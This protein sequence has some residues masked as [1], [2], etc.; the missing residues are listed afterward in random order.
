[1]GMDSAPAHGWV[2]SDEKLRELCPGEYQAL[3]DALDKTEDGETLGSLA[4]SLNNEVE[5]EDEELFHAYADLVEAFE[6]ATTIVEDHEREWNVQI[7]HG[8]LTLNLCY[9]DEDT[10]GSYDEISGDHYWNVEGMTQLTPAG[11]KFSSVVEQKS[12]TQFG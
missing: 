2:I 6:K 8:H 5:L 10:G 3:I 9:Y 11:Q 4:Q 1:M 7:D 12:W